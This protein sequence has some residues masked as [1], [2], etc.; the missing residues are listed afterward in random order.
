MA[1]RTLALD[2]SST[3]LG[4]LESW[5]PSLRNFSGLMLNSAQP[6]FMAWGPE[7]TWLYND[8]F[9]PILGR[10]HPQALGHPSREVWSEAWQVLEPMFDQVFAGQPVQMEDISLELDRRGVLEEAHF[11]FS[12][13]PAPD[14]QGD[15]G[16]L[17]GTCIETTAQ[18]QSL[19]LAQ[20]AEERLQM[21][22]AVG[23]G[24]GTWDWD[25]LANRLVADARFAKLYGVD[26]VKAAGGAP[27]AEF[28]RAVHP[29]DAP[30][31]RV[32]IDKALADCAD[33]SAEYR[34]VQANG[35]ERWVSAQGRC[36]AGADG[37]AARFPGVTFDITSRKRAELKRE[38]LVML[39]DRIR[40]M[41]DPEELAY[42]AAEILGQTLGISRAGYGIVD[43]AAETISINRDWHAPGVATLAG[44]LHFRNYGSY[45]ED[46]AR[47]DTVVL[48]DAELDPRTAAM[49][50]A[51]KAID[52]RALVN[53]PVT[54]Q[55]GLVALLYLSHA[56]PRPW[57]SEDLALVREFAART[58]TATERLRVTSALRDSEMRL[59]QANETLEA[60]VA[61]RTRELMQ[62][63]EALRQSQKMEAIGQLTG[64]IAHDFNNLLA[65][66]DGCL[67]LLE[68]HLSEGDLSEHER[69][70]STAQEAT[71]RAAALTQ[72]LLA[73]SRRQTLDPRP[74]DIN[75]MIASLFD[76]LQRSVGPHVQI[77]VVPGEDLWVTKLDE[78]QLEN[79]LL[80]LCINARDAMAPDG[81]KITIETVNKCLDEAEAREYQLPAGHYVL[82]TVTDTGMGMTP[83]VMA[84]AFDPFFTTKPLGQGTGLGLSMIY[85]FVRQSG[86]GV[87]IHSKAQSGTTLSLYLPRHRGE[88][89]AE[90]RGV[91]ADVRVGA[92]EVVLVID[93][94]PVIRMLVTEVLAERGYCVIEAE[95]G[96]SG[97]QLLQ[98]VPQVDLLV[99]DVGLPGGLNGRQVADA[100]RVTRPDLKILFITGYAENAAIGDG[101]LE[102]GMSV[103]TKPFDLTAFANKIHELIDA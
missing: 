74:L 49:A 102:P 92:G 54:E 58:R 85:G 76:L 19:R 69:Y 84:K 51:L 60:N 32:A 90:D 30:Q 21:A 72:R 15:I 4:P 87:Q 40:D 53:M 56:D 12:Y 9:I 95:D 10:K 97:L 23:G 55:G 82:L 11:A 89:V 96:P 45:I 35:S 39:T 48:E 65:G 67:G 2:W 77:R 66:I 91:D 99:T 38:A 79:T 6:M 29:E 44:T 62:A 43:I 83:D 26:P 57:P 27:L 68:K 33:F 17:F 61:A 64:G 24:V 73:F 36:V 42:A 70:I 1:D 28:F 63:E 20:E 46:L 81:G 22:L 31:V 98:T 13:N 86:G 101:Q 75:R 50:D 71:R 100:A 18:I 34:L 93:D 94:E 37:R 80:N 3:P 16:G 47:G 78:G 103:I 5:P 7:R 59:R 52:A 88:V 41:D 14:Q 8:A 25:V